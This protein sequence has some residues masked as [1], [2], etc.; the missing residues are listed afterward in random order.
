ME[1]AILLSEPRQFLALG[2][3]QAGPTLR[4]IGLCAADPDAEIGLGEVEV[5]GDARD[6]LALVEYSRTA[7]ALK[8]SSN[9]RRGRCLELFAIG[10]DTVSIFREMSTKPDQAQNRIK[11]SRQAK[12]LSTHQGHP[13]DR[14]CAGQHLGRAQHPQRQR[15]ALY[16]D[17]P[18]PSAIA[19]STFSDSAQHPRR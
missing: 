10:R 11:P 9:R 17:S 14:R 19:L 12:P 13:L 16:G 1:L 18:A 3:H 2:R 7:C 4:A 8:S 5:T 6:A 15:P